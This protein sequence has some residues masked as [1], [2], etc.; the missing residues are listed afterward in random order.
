MDMKN[1]P[2]NPSGFQWFDLTKDDTDY[3]LDQSIKAEKK[4]N[5]LLMRLNKNLI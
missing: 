1:C 3:I 5:Y 2:I 4:L